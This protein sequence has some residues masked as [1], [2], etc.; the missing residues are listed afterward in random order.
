MGVG[1][2]CMIDFQSSK[3]FLLEIIQNVGIFLIRRRLYWRVDF[4]S[5][6]SILEKQED[7]NNFE[8]R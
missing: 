4:F 2:T 8:S 3:E 7:G 1:N 5:V 6:C